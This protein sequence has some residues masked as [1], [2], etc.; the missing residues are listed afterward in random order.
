MLLVAWTLLRV[1]TIEEGI[2]DVVATKHT[3]RG[4]NAQTDQGLAALSREPSL[5]AAERV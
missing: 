2:K 4:I 1:D 3:A 5:L